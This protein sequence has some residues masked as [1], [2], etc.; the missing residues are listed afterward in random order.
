LSLLDHPPK[1]INGNWQQWAQRIST[2]LAQ[3]RSTLRH[4]VTGESAAEDGV[5]LWDQVGKYPVV[6]VDGAFVGVALNS[7]FTVSALPAGVVGQRA[8]V[9]DAASPT[10]G[11]TLTGGGAVVVPVF[12]NATAWV[13]G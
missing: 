11:S 6:S 9:T 4:K 1:L 13:V 10:F 3:T 5:L 8:Y 7:G 2:W 12:R